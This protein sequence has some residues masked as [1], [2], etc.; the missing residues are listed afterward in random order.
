MRL[1]TIQ[2][3][4]RTWYRNEEGAWETTGEPVLAAW[5]YAGVR[6]WVWVNLSAP[7]GS[8]LRD[9]HAGFRTLRDAMRAAVRATRMATL[10]APR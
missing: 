7:F 10:L 6:P 9:E 5:D 3:D 1:R 8:D 4:G 2:C